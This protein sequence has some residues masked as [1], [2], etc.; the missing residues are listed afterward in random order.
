MPTETPNGHFTAGQLRAALW[1]LRHLGT[2]EE[3]VPDVKRFRGKKV[4]TELVSDGL[5]TLARD[6]LLARN[7]GGE[8][9]QAAVEVFREI[10]DFLQT[11]LPGST[12]DPAE[13]TAFVAGFQ[14]QLADHQKRFGV[15]PR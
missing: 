11:A 5:R 8:R 13:E 4:P 1:V 9:W 2:P 14:K 15:L 3:T 6:L 7:R 10:P 12:M